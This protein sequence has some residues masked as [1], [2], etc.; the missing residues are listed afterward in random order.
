MLI[1]HKKHSK[2]KH[3]LMETI[4]NVLADEFKNKITNF[5]KTEKNPTIEVAESALLGMA[6]EFTAQSLSA[7]YEAKDKELREDKKSRKEQGL[8]IERAGDSREI[9]TMI[10][11]LKYSR[12]YYKKKSGGYIYPIDEYAGVDSYMR[13]SGGTCLALIQAATHQSY[14]KSSF[15]VTDGIISKQTVMNKIREATVPEYKAA[16]PLKTVPYLHIDADEDHVKLAGGKGTCTAVPLI[17]V[18]EGI[19]R[20]GKRGICINSFSISVY[21]K[22]PDEIWDKVLTE[23]EHRYDI[24]KTK[25]YIHGD[26]AAWIRAAR[27]W[28]PGSVFV[29]DQYHKNKYLLQATSGFTAEEC[30]IYRAKIRKILKSGDKNELAVVQAEMCES[31][32]EMV[33]NIMECTGYLL[34]NFDAIYIRNIDEE[35]NN[36]GSTEPHV[37][38]ILSSRLSTRPMA[39]SRKTLEHIAPILAA[40]ACTLEKPSEKEPHII[41]CTRANCIPKHAKTAENSLGLP[42]PDHATDIAGSFKGHLSGLYGILRPLVGFSKS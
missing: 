28:F 35:A 20:Q 16:K 30:K 33:K 9:I 39:W 13:V 8:T 17:T 29:L 32:P 25:I 19:K 22:S 2:E 4:I 1:Y 37:S 14:A 5:L 18:Y 31:H 38:H 26:G 36:G 40:G 10:G 6:L 3:S 12:T 24:S 7:L 41:C 42:D 15:E 34:G 27:E 23:I 21:N 11:A